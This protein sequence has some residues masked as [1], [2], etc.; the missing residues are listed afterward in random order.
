MNNDDQIRYLYEEI[1]NLADHIIED[2]ESI[3]VDYEY[4]NHCRNKINILL[5]KIIEK[6]ERPTDRKE[7]GK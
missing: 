2:Q 6:E 4:V 5:N 3:V 7:L 1:K